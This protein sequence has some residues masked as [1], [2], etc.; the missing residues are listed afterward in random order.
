MLYYTSPIPKT[1]ISFED[2]REVPLTD[3]DF[4]HCAVKLLEETPVVPGT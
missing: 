4:A 3:D 2:P 1:V